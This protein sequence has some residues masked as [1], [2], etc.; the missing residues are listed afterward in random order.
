MI[1]Y[2]PV[3]EHLSQLVAQYLARRDTFNE[4]TFF[5]HEEQLAQSSCGFLLQG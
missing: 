4:R 3:G 2:R 5:S 1:P